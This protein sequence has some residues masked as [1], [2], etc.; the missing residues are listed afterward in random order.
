L[1]YQLTENQIADYQR[2]GFLSPIQVFDEQEVTSLK[3]HFENFENHFGG[4]DKAASFRTDLHLL[5]DWAWSVINDPRI[6]KPITQVL[7]PNVLL[8]ST[9]WFIKEP[10][11][12]KVVSFHQDANYWGLEPHDITTAWL[13]LT[14]AS[15]ETGP[16]NFVPGSHREEL[17]DHTNTFAENNLL[18]RG[19]EINRNIDIKLCKLAPLKAGE[20]SM[21]HVRTIHNSGPN[22]SKERRIGMVLRYCAT[23]VHQTKG[24]D[25]AVL[26]AGQDEYRNFQLL[27]RPQIDFGENETKIHQ[28]ATQKLGKIIMS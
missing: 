17:L 13:A 28:D 24:S 20:M 19:Q 25:T 1:N 22:E 5:Q 23:H 16:M 14:D 21:H 15:I 27:N 9:Q 2:D 3:L 7:G 12:R 10:G 18:S 26:V 8:W 6:I 4:I 11:D